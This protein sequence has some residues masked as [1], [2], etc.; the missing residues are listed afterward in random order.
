MALN[1]VKGAEWLQ[2]QFK[3]W[4]R[5]VYVLKWRKNCSQIHFMDSILR[6]LLRRLRLLKLE[7]FFS[8]FWQ[9]ASPARLKTPSEIVWSW[10]GLVITDNQWVI[11]NR[12]VLV[13]PWA[14]GSSGLYYLF[15][16]KW[17]I[18][19]WTVYSLLL[20][21]FCAE[22]G[23]LNQVVTQWLTASLA[24]ISPNFGYK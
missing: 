12:C 23:I 24:C 11:D 19:I 7:G 16:K 9:V 14:Q 21:M 6:F 18:K 8:F 17:Q 5:L 2:T 3:T 20:H 10:R 13:A 4:I 15:H 22:I 1:V